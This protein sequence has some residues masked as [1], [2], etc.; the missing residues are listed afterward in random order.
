MAF[1][2]VPV[3]I[4]LGVAG[5]VWLKGKASPAP[6]APPGYPVPPA[7]PGTLQP[8][9]ANAATYDPTT[10]RNLANPVANDLRANLGLADHLLIIQ[11]QQAAG[12]K[13]DGIY[14]P[15][16]RGALI[17]FGAPN[18]PLP[19]TT[20]KTT[21]QYLPPGLM[22][23]VLAHPGPSSAPSRKRGLQG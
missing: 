12:L 9:R 19:L 13:P 20:N 4:A 8:T 21:A 11:F 5:V 3:L 2:V 6:A 10:A 1:P 16:T 14:V 17:Y 22:V 23:A 7:A 18:P 15:R